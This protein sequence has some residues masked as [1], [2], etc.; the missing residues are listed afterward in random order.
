MI[1]PR[2]YDY[3]WRAL[4]QEQQ[5]SGLSIS[6]FCLTKKIPYQTF[7]RNIANLQISNESFNFI[8]IELSNED[9]LHVTINGNAI[10]INKTID[11]ISLSRILKA[12]AS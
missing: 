7:R 9:K 4:S 8:P 3:D 12:L 2:K 6:Q 11:D 10:S 5:D 1:M